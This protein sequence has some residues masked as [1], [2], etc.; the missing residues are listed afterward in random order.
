MENGMEVPEQAKYR[1]SMILDMYPLLDTYLEKTKTL[2]RNITRTPM[3]IAA[4]FTIT[5]TWKQALDSEAV[6]YI[7]SLIHISEPT[8]PY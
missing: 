8:R 1:T 7:L 3:F 6:V 5:K 4:L 2:I